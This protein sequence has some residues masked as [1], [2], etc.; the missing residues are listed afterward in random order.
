MNRDLEIKTLTVTLSESYL[1]ITRLKTVYLIEKDVIDIRFRRRGKDPIIRNVKGEIIKIGIDDDDRKYIVVLA[2]NYGDD[3]NVFKIHVDEFREIININHSTEPYSFGPV[4]CPDE[5][6]I[7]IKAVDGALLFSHDGENW[8][9]AGSACSTE[10]MLI[11]KTGL[12]TE[13]DDE[14]SLP[15]SKVVYDTI[16]DLLPS[17]LFDDCVAAGWEYSRAALAKVIVELAKNACRI[18][19]F[20]YTTE[21][22]VNNGGMP[23]DEEEGG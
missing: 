17:D 3:D 8:T 10:G 4:Y 2:Y 21:D 5:T 20:Y 6:A 1:G 13:E 19:T 11:K 18:P 14:N 23:D 9:A 7:M 16:M 15:S 22:Y 12:I